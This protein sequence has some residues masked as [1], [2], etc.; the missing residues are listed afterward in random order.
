MVP[1]GLL[2]LLRVSRETLGAFR[3][4]NPGPDFS[5]G[6]QA[7]VGKQPLKEEPRKGTQ[8][9]DIPGKQGESGHKRLQASGRGAGARCDLKAEAARDRKSVV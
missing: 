5:P 3:E 9:A 8:G 7:D 4:K 1:A 6:H 2:A